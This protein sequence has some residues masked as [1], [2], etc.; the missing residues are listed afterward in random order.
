[1]V[2]ETRLIE[3]WVLRNALIVPDHFF[4]GGDRFDHWKTIGMNNFDQV[5]QA[6]VIDIPSCSK[7]G[8]RLA[9]MD[10][11]DKRVQGRVTCALLATRDRD[12]IFILLERASLGV[13]TYKRVGMAVV[14]RDEL[15]GMLME[16][17]TITIV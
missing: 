3:G 13:D 9:H 17:S 6:I 10:D 11:D 5:P 1:V 15:L 4:W 2:I 8:L 16:C 14:S 12:M 7:P